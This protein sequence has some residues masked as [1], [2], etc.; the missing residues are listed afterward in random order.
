MHY[1]LVNSVE[2]MLSLDFPNIV[3]HIQSKKDPDYKALT[4]YKKYGYW[5]N[6]LEVEARSFESKWYMQCFEDMVARG[7]IR[8]II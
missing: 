1:R 6:R 4:N 5:G 2:E 3:H 8:K 7:I